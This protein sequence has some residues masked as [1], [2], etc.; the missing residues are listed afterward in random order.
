MKISKLQVGLLICVAALIFGLINYKLISQNSGKHW[1][2][3]LSGRIIVLDA[4]H[5]GP[6]GGATGGGILEKNVTLSIAE[7]L[8]DYLQQSG[9]VVVM[10]REEDKDLADEDPTGRRKTQDLMR[11][12]ALI[13]KTDPDC[14]VS[15]HLNA[16]PSERWRGA[17]T[18]YFPKSK[19]NES[20][21]KFIQDSIKVQLENTDRYAKPINHVYILK[22]IKPPA[23]LVEVGFLSN[24]EERA[25]L[26]TS[27]YQRKVA[28]SIYE[29]MMRYFTNEK[30]PKP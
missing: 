16:I 20:L 5:G 9:A 14:V 13:K 21:A 1:N 17:Q 3:P 24:P 30:T 8:K 15:I 27:N 6:D 10:T 22:K 12:V 11:R 4:G 7:H 29:G 23:A 19:E 26:S 25:L 18:F 28:V 2:L